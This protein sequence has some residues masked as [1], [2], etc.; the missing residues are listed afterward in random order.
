MENAAEKA[1]NVN[2]FSDALFI[3]FLIATFHLGK[4]LGLGNQHAPCRK[5][6]GK[7]GGVTLRRSQNAKVSVHERT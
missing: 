2:V 4:L 3:A 5:I 7:I 6:A 1:L